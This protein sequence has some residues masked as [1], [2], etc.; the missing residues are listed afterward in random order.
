MNPFRRSRL[1]AGVVILLVGLAG[2]AIGAAIDRA[3]EHRR[4]LSFV[5]GGRVPKGPPPEARKWVLSRLQ[6][7]LGLSTQQRIQVD[8]VLARREAEVRGLM[9][10]MQ[11]RFEAISARTRRDLQAALTPDQQKRFLDMSKRAGPTPTR[12]EPPAH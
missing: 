11:P 7:G 4:M 12:D 5:V 8:S 9:L 10:E 3:V 6:S 2:V 1:L